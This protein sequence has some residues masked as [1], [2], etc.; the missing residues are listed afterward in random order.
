M[1]HCSAKCPLQHSCNKCLIIIF[2][3]N[4]TYKCLLFH[5]RLLPAPSVSIKIYSGV[6]WFPFPC[7]GTAFMYI[8]SH[9]M[10][11]I[12]LDRQKNKKIT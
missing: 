3:K 10:R 6:T 12:I 11:C 2:H 1:T 7:D 4:F 5:Q 9:A 8:L